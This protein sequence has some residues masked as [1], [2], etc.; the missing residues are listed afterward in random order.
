[1]ESPYVGRAGLELLASSDP[2]TLDSPRFWEAEV[3]RSRGQEIETI[4]ANMM[5]PHL[6]RLRQENCLDVGGGGC[7]E[8][9]LS[10]CTPAWA[11]VR[12]SIL[13]KKK[14][15][16]ESCSVSRL[17]CSGEISAHCSLH[18]PD[19]GDCPP[20]ACRV[21]AVTSAMA[22]ETARSPPQLHKGLTLLHRL[23][24]GGTITAHCSLNLSGSRNPQP[25]DSQ[26]AGTTET[27]FYCVAQAVLKLLCSSYP[28]ALASQSAGIT[29]T[30]GTEVGGLLEP[31]SSRLQRAVIVSLH[32]SLSNGS[33]TMSPKKEKER[34]KRSLAL[35][36]RLEC[37]GMI[38]AHCNS[39]LPGS[40]D[41]P[42]S[43]SRVAGITG[44]CH[45]ARLIFV[46]S[47]ETEFC[48]VIQDGLNHLTL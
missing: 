38:S 31:R 33:E 4:L 15:K 47:V 21:E 12:D 29:A 45:H 5:K 40:S 20:S 34:K 43:A 16:M 18:L 35:S 37:N 41:S 25:S 23:E 7:S 3:G 17:E 30:S 36:P 9:R 22:A 44:V 24:C 46:F 11:T 42:A 13:D 8:P 48:H 1:M 2:H 26:V 10:H 39:C 27:R 19:S 14:K 32:S 6:R 28:S